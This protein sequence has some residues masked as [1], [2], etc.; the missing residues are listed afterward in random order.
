[1][2]YIIIDD[3]VKW[4]ENVINTIKRL[5]ED[6]NIQHSFKQ[7]FGD[8]II[9][10]LLLSTDSFGELIDKLDNADIIFTD[11][12]FGGSER[13]LNFLKNLNRGIQKKIVVLTQYKGDYQN[14]ENDFPQVIAW[15]EK[16]LKMEALVNTIDRIYIQMNGLR[17][18][19]GNDFVEIVARQLKI[20]YNS[21]NYISTGGAELVIVLQ[22]N[23]EYTFSANLLCLQ[24]FNKKGGLRQINSGFIININYEIENNYAWHCKLQ[25]KN[26]YV[27][28]TKL[29]NMNS[30]KLKISGTFLDAAKYLMERDN[31]K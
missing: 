26:F 14:Q 11:I 13:G 3:E 28:N 24:H 19:H 18:V 10:N 16:P 21:I 8:N 30:Q 20:Y 6:A 15:L 4:R 31:R 29:K 25:G 27:E 5:N 17:A 23:T 1:M 7:K 9:L 2:T 22:D 12:R